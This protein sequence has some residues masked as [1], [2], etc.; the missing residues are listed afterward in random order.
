VK[1]NTGTPGYKSPLQIPES[2]KSHSCHLLTLADA[3]S[4]AHLYTE[5][6]L[7]DEPTTCRYA[8]DFSWF[9]PYAEEYVRILANKKLSFIIRE[10]E[11]GE[12]A[13]FVF[14]LDLTD[15]PEQEGAAMGEFLSHFRGTI[16]M[17]QELEDRH[18]NREELPPGSVLHVYQIGV[19]KLFRG[20]GIAEGMIHQ[21]ISHAWELG[22]SRIVADCTGMGSKRVFEGCG[23]HEVEYIQYDM[24]ERD[25]IRFFEGLN[26]GI[27]LMIRDL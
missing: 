12:L 20:R 18:F 16:E 2:L 9:L 22:Y 4:A 21:V 13:G 25:G 23:F 7:A 24:F 8:P 15:N 11:T 14:C 19:G 26:G 3:D 1:F 17:M 6:F 5:I 10:K 27:S